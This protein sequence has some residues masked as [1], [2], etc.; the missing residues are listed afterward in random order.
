[1]TEL[2]PDVG[3]GRKNPKLKNALLQHKTFSL[4]GLSERLFGL[5]F[6][7]LVY[8]QIWEDPIVDME[9]MQLGPE[10]RIVTIGS[11][12]CNMLTYLS[13]GPREIDVVDLNP[14][15]IALNRLK[16][17]AF[18][19]LPSHKDVTRF[20]ATQGTAA[21]VQAFDLFIAPK[22][23]TATRSYWN[24]RDLTGRRRIGVFGRNIY[25]TGLLGRFIAASHL[26]ARLHGVNPEEFVQA[27]SM[28]EQRQF[29]DERLAPL[30]DRPVIRWITGR[31]SS[32][33]GLGIPPQQF[34]ELA[35]L[36]S[37]KSLAAVLRHR[38]EK[39]TC[40]FPLRENYFAWQAFGRRY[41][42]PHEGELPPYL[43]ARAYEAIRNNAERV[44][45][46]HASYTEL[47]ASKPAASV[48]RYILLDAQDWMTDQQLND[49]WTEITRTADTGAIVIFRTAAEDSIL[50]GRVS[51]ALLDQWH[52]DA[53]AS[54]KLGAE[55]RSAIY[56]GFH[57]YRKKA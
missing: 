1:M 13:A 49:L 17:A 34:D 9:A 26:L 5:L 52:Y 20:L 23:D 7:G 10:H 8:P 14:H 27:G 15:H 47:L 3:F 41:P 33:F 45:V 42:L 30:F 24:G 16:L 22:L 29:F 39:L 2:A 36:S 21:N 38:L 19:H 4:A 44:E 35:S 55:D 25:R 50:P 46:H 11:G 18:R 12:G 31:K 6:S 57:I 28:R 51:S 40:H 53:E 32:L 48:D 54:V 56:G 43:N 37:E